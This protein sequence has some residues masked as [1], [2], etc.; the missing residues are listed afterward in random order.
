MSDK[1]RHI[2]Q[3]NRIDSHEINPFNTD[4]SYLTKEEEPKME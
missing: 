2:D 1:K 4:S 3:W